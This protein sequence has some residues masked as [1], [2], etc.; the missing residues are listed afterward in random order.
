MVAVGILYKCSSCKYSKEIIVGGDS[1]DFRRLHHCPKCKELVKTISEC[2]KCGSSD[3]PR[4]VTK[5]YCDHIKNHRKRT[6]NNKDLSKEKKEELI[7]KIDEV[8]KSRKLTVAPKCPKCGKDT[9]T[10]SSF[11]V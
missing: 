8:N 1:F 4:Y 3:L 11:N 6:L 9:M 2:P 10:I 5:E 7:K